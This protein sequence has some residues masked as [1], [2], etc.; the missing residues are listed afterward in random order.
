MRER[1]FVY[2]TKNKDC[3]GLRVILG[4]ETKVRKLWLLGWG[5]CLLYS[6]PGPECPG[7]SAH[8]PKF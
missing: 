6:N 3:R 8:S 2:K 5:L 1:E 7:M 4:Q